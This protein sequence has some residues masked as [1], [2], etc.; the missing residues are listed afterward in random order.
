[1]TTDYQASS[2]HKNSKRL[3]VSIPEEEYKEL[4][5]LAIRMRVSLAWLVRDAVR[6]YLRRD[7][8]RIKDGW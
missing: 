7:A 8:K 4:Q 2:D 1:M 3:S 6:K 5:E